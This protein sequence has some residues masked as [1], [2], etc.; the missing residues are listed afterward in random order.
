MAKGS[1]ESE[2]SAISSS[3]S[4]S[5]TAGTAGFKTALGL[6]RGDSSSVTCALS[7]RSLSLHFFLSFYLRSPCHSLPLLEFVLLIHQVL[8]EAANAEVQDLFSR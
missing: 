1:N 3:I 7:P 8:L 2:L 6:V 5:G 4:A